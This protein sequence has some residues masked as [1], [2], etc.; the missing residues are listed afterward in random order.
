MSPNDHLFPVVRLLE[1]QEGKAEFFDRI[2][3][4]DPEQVFLQRAHEP[5]G[6]AVALGLS[7]ES[8]R[9]P[10]AQEGNLFLKHTGNVL[11]TFVMSQGQA[12]CHGGSK[13]SKAVE[14]S[15]ANRL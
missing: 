12:L 9:T 8:R 4:P 14:H 3:P 5:F 13:G 15:L 2:K 11:A 6:D 1:L 10:D 7:D